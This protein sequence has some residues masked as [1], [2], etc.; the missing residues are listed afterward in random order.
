M[1]AQSQFAYGTS[2]RGR[3]VFGVNVRSLRLAKGLSQEK[4]ADLCNLHRTYIGPVERGEHNISIDSMERI[5]DA[6]GISVSEM[7]QPGRS[8]DGSSSASPEACDPSVR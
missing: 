8:V 5:A 1:K 7:L 4:L 2:E 6:L 3:K